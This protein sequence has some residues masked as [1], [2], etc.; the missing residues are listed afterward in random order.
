MPIVAVENKR[1]VSELVVYEEPTARFSRDEITIA[2]EPKIGDL[3]RLASAGVYSVITDKADLKDACFV[4]IYDTPETPSNRYAVIARL[5]RI[6]KSQ[7]N[8]PEGAT[9]ADKQLAIDALSKHLIVVN[10]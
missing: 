4:A 2:G 8:W 10:D 7:I 9:E 3:I 6:R 1:Y 5:A